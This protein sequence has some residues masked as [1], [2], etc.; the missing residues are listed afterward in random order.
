MERLSISKNNKEEKKK[1]AEEEKKGK[2][3]SGGIEERNYPCR[4]STQLAA[5]R[6]FY[7]FNKFCT[8]VIGMMLE[9]DLDQLEGVENE[10][11]VE[12]EEEEDAK[13]EE[14]NKENTD[15]EQNKE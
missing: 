3:S 15:E 7:N 6:G 11:D 9:E 8:E 2:R 4:C 12:E 10:P 13:D 14:E 1:K 5:C